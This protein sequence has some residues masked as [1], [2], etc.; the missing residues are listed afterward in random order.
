MLIFYGIAV[1]CLTTIAVFYINYKQYEATVRTWN[2][3]VQGWLLVKCD[4]LC[5]RLEAYAKC[6]R[7]HNNMISGEDFLKFVNYYRQ[8]VVDEL[9][10]RP[11]KEERGKQKMILIFSGKAKDFTP[12]KWQ[13]IETTPPA[14]K[15]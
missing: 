15:K 9:V 13:K 3:N 11:Y 5:D 4:H 6:V 7:L 10:Y 2:A 8:I 12:E 14:S 1:V